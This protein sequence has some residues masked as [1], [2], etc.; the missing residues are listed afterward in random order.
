MMKERARGTLLY[1][2]CQHV[3]YLGKEVYCVKHGDRIL[4]G[5]PDPRRIRVVY[6][7]NQLG[8]YIQK[9]LTFGWQQAV[10]GQ[11]T[12]CQQAAH[13]KTSCEN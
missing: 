10:G 6:Q 8:R 5:Q 13:G 1:L 9:A 4:G 11:A 7:A 12:V 3:D 2:E